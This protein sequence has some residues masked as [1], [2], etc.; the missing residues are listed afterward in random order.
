MCL[1]IKWREIVGKG[2]SSGCGKYSR[3]DDWINSEWTGYGGKQI[4]FI[5]GAKIVVKLIPFN[6][7]N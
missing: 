2:N 3:W 4:E 5:V 6:E 1:V 7:I